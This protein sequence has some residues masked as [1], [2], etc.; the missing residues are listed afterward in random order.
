MW[1]RGVFKG[2]AAGPADGI[3]FIDFF[4]F[5]LSR[6]CISDICHLVFICDLVGE[7][8]LVYD[9]MSK[10]FLLC[11]ALLESVHPGLGTPD[12]HLGKRTVCSLQ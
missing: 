6:A 7:Q 8:L 2:F 11:F 5:L 3:Y 10:A 1:A 12:A 4:V 9:L